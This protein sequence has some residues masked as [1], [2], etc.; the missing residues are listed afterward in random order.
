MVTTENAEDW[1]QPFI[2]YLQIEKLS[3]DKSTVHE[4]RKRAL[5]YALI[6]NVMYRRSFDQWWL[7]CVNG[8][9]AQE[10]VKD[11]HSGLCGAHQPEH[12]LKKYEKVRKQNFEHF[13]RLQ[14]KYVNILEG[15]ELHT[16]V[17]ILTVSS[18][19]KL[20]SVSFWK[21]TWVVL[22]KEGNPPGMICHDKVDP[23]PSFIKRMIKRLVT[24]HTLPADCIP[25]SCIVNIYVA[26]DFL[27][28]KGNGADVAKHYILGVLYP[29]VS[30][31]FRRMNEDNMSF[32]FRPDPEIESL[33]PYEL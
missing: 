28:L 4:I 12:E 20:W 21:E 33:Q 32:R 2:E 10:T 6:D 7:R 24:W 14:G 22:D 15:L 9:K 5:P 26:G 25:N 23:L 11:V 17:F 29:R 1:R 27:V 8:L 18:S 13:Q 16:N 30:I 31:T 19:K 3:D